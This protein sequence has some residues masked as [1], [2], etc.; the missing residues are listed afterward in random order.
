MLATSNRLYVGNL[1]AQIRSYEVSGSSPI[2]RWIQPV[3]AGKNIR[4]NLQIVVPTPNPD[5]FFALDE[6]GVLHGY[7]D[8]IPL[9]TPLWPSTD[10]GGIG[11]RSMGTVSPTL[12][13]L[14]VGR[15]DGYVQQLNINTGGVDAFRAI[16]A[17]GT[18]AP[19]AFSTLG[20]GSPEDRLIAAALGPDGVVLHQ[21]CAP[22]TPTGCGAA[23]A[24]EE[25]PGT[26]S[27]ASLLSATNPFR[28][29]TRLRGTLPHAARL[30]IVV[31]D[32]QGSRIRTFPVGIVGAGDWS[33][34][35]DGRDDGGREVP[36]GVYLYRLRAIAPDRPP[37][38]T[39]RTFARLR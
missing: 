13:K 8:A 1:S 11:Y 22:W 2:L 17:T 35:W 19:A 37:I 29:A 30:E 34:E 28:E 21:Y 38:E 36:S 10:G 4:K 32:L 33:L 18:T 14:Y 23:V 9:P 31:F 7:S 25:S 24:V 16:G 27:R 3:A 12:G 5:R 15:N 20:T 26:A 39:S 6:G